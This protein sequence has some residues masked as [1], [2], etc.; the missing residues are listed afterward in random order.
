MDENKKILRRLVLSS[1][2]LSQAKRFVEFILENKLYLESTEDQITINRSLQT[3]AIVSYIRPFS[4]N[5]DKDD[6]FGTLD[7]KHLSTLTD[8]E[9]K[10]HNHIK[11]LRNQVLAHTDSEVRGLKINITNFAGSKTAW[12]SSH[13]PF[14]PLPK[15]HW[16]KFLDIINKI[17]GSITEDIVEMQSQFEKYDS[18]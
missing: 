18:F 1:T 7:K 9:L 3:S 15:E 8:D 12:S 2:D 17:D 13:N 14:A 16:S 10:F 6:T 11:S 5:Y 4:G